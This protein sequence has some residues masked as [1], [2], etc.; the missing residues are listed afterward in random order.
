MCYALCTPHTEALH[1]TERYRM[2]DYEAAKDGFERDAKER[3]VAQGMRNPN[4]RGKYLQLQFTVEDQ[5]VF[6]MPWTATMTYG[7]GPADWMEA[8]LRRKHSVVLGTGRRRTAGEQAGFLR[9]I[10]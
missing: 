8:V 2:L 10:G 6:T 5:G 4:H 3:N 9:D 7:R 1:V